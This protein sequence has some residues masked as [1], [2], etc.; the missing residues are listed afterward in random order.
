MTSLFASMNCWSQYIAGGVN[1][2]LVLCTGGSVTA[3]GANYYGQLGDGTTA[4]RLTPIRVTNLSG[5]VAI[6]TEWH[7]SLALKSDRTVWAWG[8]NN[9]GQLGDGTSINRLIP[10]QVTGLSGIIAISSGY[11]HS[12]ALKDDGTVWAWGW[13]ATGQLGDGTTMTRQTPVQ[14]SGLSEIIAIAG[15]EWHSLALRSDGTV[16]AWGYGGSGQLGNGTTTTRLTPVQVA[17]LSEIIAIA[18]GAS[19]SLALKSD[20]TVMTWGLNWFGQIGD[21]TTANRLTPVQVIVLSGATAISGGVHHSI[22]LKSNG[23]VWAWGYGTLGQLGDGTTT[24]RLTPVQVS[25]LSGI[26]AIS[27]SGYCHSLAL[28]SDET[29]SAWGN[30]EYGQLGDG[31]TIMRLAPVQMKT[32]LVTDVVTLPA[33]TGECS[34]S[35]TSVP[36]AS[37]CDGAITINGTT[38]DPLVY[39]LP[40][41]YTVNW[42]YDDGYGN[43]ITQTQTVIVQDVTPPVIV[44]LSSPITFVKDNIN[45]C[46]SSQSNYVEL[47]ISSLYTSLSDN[48]SAT[49]NIIEVSSDEEDDADGNWDGCTEDDIDLHVCNK[50][51]LRKECDTRSDGRVYRITLEARD[52]SY[53][54]S[55]EYAYVHIKRT[56][57]S[58]VDWSGEANTVTC[59]SPKI[60]HNV[61]L[62]PQSVTLY[63]NFPNPF[64]PTTSI[65]YGIPEDGYVLLRVFDV[66][67]RVV[68]TLV[69]E[70]KEAGTHFVTFDARNLESGVYICELIVAGQM[71]S[72]RMVL[73]K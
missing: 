30:N 61:A 6:S 34:A 15:G 22:A 50:V 41:T 67:G 47:D 51:E 63:Q 5:I 29:V 16:W 4:M 19:H 8:W 25:G 36:T 38:S 62:V 39:T 71:R 13:N 46:S 56:P 53:N 12:L 7:H 42:F 32:V 59:G 1:H 10:I 21:G 49:I 17:G 65:T 11:Y 40:G 18:S 27:G 45:N 26:T 23:T 20:G 64:N 72:R 2:S 14:V 57:L 31:T 9:F 70:A 35:I 33:I 66:H 37:T 28:K 55:T 54:T 69:N 48:C 24:T 3:T 44:P 43:T 58:S 60:S 73:L 68:S 52:P